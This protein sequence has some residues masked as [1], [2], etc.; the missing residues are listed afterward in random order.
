M[1][2][3]QTQQFA[4]PEEALIHFGV[5]G[6]RWGV[7]KSDES[8]NDRSAAKEVVLRNEQ[9]KEGLTKDL[10]T[11]KD[12]P[13]V[14]PTS[15]QVKSK[16]EVAAAADRHGLTSNQKK[17][18][19]A[20]GVTAGVAGF[21]AYKHYTKSPLIDPYSLGKMDPKFLG[22]DPKGLKSG[23]ISSLKPGE[24]HASHYHLNLKRP[25]ELI[26]DVSKGYADI[27]PLAGFANA[28]VE[29]RHADIIRQLDEFREMYPAIR[30]MNIEVIPMSHRGGVQGGYAACVQAIRPGEARI[31][32]NDILSR[33]SEQNAA[34]E[35]FIPGITKPG[36]V[37]AHELGHLLA[38]AGNKQ[39]SVFGATEGMNNA[40]AGAFKD[41]LPVEQA[42]RHSDLL[43]K[44]G[45]S[46]EQLAK[47]N[48]YAASQPEEA[49]AELSRYYHIPENRKHLDPATIEKAKALFDELG[50][51]T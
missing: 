16:K 15:P 23:P 30:N 21:I 32:Y 44:H 37:G 11:K 29:A 6:M 1:I 2:L 34:M 20:L 22:F 4:S 40:Q 12:D 42:K 39:I 5:K 47:L 28:E 38:V 13:S 51:V 18:L 9:T 33:T 19:V 36:N 45:L 46:F 48:G 31:V 49:L 43:K 8:T 41:A 27:R 10:L 24:L 26:V 35:A 50:G 3:G 7:R 14:S 17:A 25:D